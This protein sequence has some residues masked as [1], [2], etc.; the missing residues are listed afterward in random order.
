MPDP[1]KKTWADMVQRRD[2]LEA[3]GIPLD[4]K[5]LRSCR[6]RWSRMS[7]TDARAAVAAWSA[8]QM[9][10]RSLPDPRQLDASGKRVAI[11]A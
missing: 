3:A 2:A 5:P 10:A 1:P 6:Y 9:T 11:W 8:G 7:S 4:G